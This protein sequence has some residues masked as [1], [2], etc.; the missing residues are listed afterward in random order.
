MF[1]LRAAQRVEQLL[2]ARVA[3]AEDECDALPLQLLAQPQRGRER[4]RA[5]ELDEVAGRLDHE[6][7]RVT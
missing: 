7:L 6:H 2:P 5:G 3:A 4:R 1:G